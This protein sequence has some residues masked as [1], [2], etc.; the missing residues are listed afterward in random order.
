MV[1]QETLLLDF[2]FVAACFSNGACCGNGINSLKPSLAER[3][4]LAAVHRTDISLITKLTEFR[5]VAELTSIME[6]TLAT[7]FAL[8]MDFTV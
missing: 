3:A 8:A 2:T 4:S 7:E 1:I 6:H 5:F